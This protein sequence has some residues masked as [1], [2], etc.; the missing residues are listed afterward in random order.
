M[1]VPKAF[2]TVFALFSLAIIL[3]SYKAI[4][5]STQLCSVHP[6]CVVFGGNLHVVMKIAPA[7]FDRHHRCIKD[8]RRVDSPL[9]ATDTVASSGMLAT[10]RQLVG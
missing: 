5:D 10:N 3:S 1:P 4:S 6:E 2:V 7:S 9:D 8:L